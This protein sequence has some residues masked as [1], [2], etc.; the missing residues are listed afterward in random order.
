MFRFW[1]HSGRILP[2]F[3]R[4]TNS[5]LYAHVKTTSDLG[6]WQ[7]FYAFCAGF[8]ASGFGESACHSGKQSDLLETLTERKTAS[9]SWP[10]P[11]H[12]V[13]VRGAVGAEKVTRR[14]R[15][16]AM[17][18]QANDIFVWC[19]GVQL[20]TRGIL[21]GNLLVEDL[22]DKW[23]I[24]RVHFKIMQE[25]TFAPIHIA[26]YLDWLATLSEPD[27]CLVWNHC[28]TTLSANQGVELQH[29]KT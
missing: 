16:L 23:Y 21:A 19:T 25:W 10:P 15:L 27:L 14:G 22:S 7:L 5:Y 20:P 18:T 4:K 2:L 1:S 29:K 11:V 3:A 24:L 26:H 9:E 13:G 17:D 8:Y 28:I 12:M 6:N